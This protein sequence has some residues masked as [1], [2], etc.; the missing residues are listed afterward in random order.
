MEEIQGN[1]IPGGRALTSDWFV[2]S[3]TMV[4]FKTII[5]FKV[6]AERSAQGTTKT[7]LRIDN[8]YKTVFEI[9]Q[10]LEMVG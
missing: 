10:K 9:N 3:F 8:H 2:N 1:L 7:N 6:Q 5:L 4:V